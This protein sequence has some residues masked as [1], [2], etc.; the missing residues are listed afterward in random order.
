MNPEFSYCLFLSGYWKKILTCYKKEAKMPNRVK[1]NHS[2][3]FK[4]SFVSMCLVFTLFQKSIC[5]K[6]FSSYWFFGFPIKIWSKTC[7]K[8]GRKSN[9]EIRESFL[10]LIGNKWFL[11]TLIGAYQLSRASSILTGH[12]SSI[13]QF[14]IIKQFTMG[15]NNFWR[16]IHLIPKIWIL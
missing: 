4:L 8:R 11:M 6:F 7:A 9:M 13:K 3:T 10:W 5:S 1:T 15:K 16:N 14:S 2:N 12:R